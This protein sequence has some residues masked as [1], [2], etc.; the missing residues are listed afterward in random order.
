MSI[1][2]VRQIGDEI[3][4]KRSK[5][6]TE[7]TDRYKELI[8]DM[9]ETMTESKGCGLA[10]VQVGVLRRIIIVQ[11]DEKEPIYTFINPVILDKSKE[12][13]EGLEGCLSVTGKKGI[14][15]RP[16]KIKFKALD[17]NMEESEYEA[18]G[19]FA[20]I[21]QH[22]VDHLE[23]ELYTEKLDGPLYNNTD[24]VPGFDDDDNDNNDDDTDEDGNDIMD[25]NEEDSK[26]ESEI[27]KIK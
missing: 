14:V 13:E 22:E 25:D 7:L 4:S 23:G 1:R 27:K 12:T 5:E 3:L 11:A 21:V 2:N 16:I 26:P 8:E 24:K 20:R 17:E 10:A 18:E 15:N 9:K 6:V 19:F